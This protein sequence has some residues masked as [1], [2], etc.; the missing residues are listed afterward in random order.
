MSSWEWFDFSV[1][2]VF[3]TATFWKM[4]AHIR[5]L[6]EKIDLWV[7]RD[8]AMQEVIKALAAENERLKRGE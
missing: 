7:M 5:K 4:S 6:E 2:A 1:M 8:E 3:V